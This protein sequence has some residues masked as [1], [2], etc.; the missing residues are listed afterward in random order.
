MKKYNIIYA[1]PP[2]EYNDKSLE[3]GGAERHYKTISLKEICEIPIRKLS[4]EDSI[5][6]MWGTWP[7]LFEAEKVINF[8]GFEYKTCAFVW[9]KTNKKTNTKQYSF[10][11]KDNL[12][13]FW[14][15]GGWTRANTEFCLLATKG[16]PKRLNCGIHQIIYSPVQ[17]HSQKPEEAKERIIKLCGDLPRIEL[18]ARQKTDGWDVWGN[19][20]E[21]DITL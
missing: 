14:G 11:P 9:V 17:K 15:M 16:N 1:D 10:L 8:W 2:W 21:S 7:K 5:L 19:E 13:S 3:R 18:F 6:F 4:N 12:D 20:V